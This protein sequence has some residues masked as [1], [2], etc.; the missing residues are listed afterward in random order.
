M[1]D[2]VSAFYT[3]HPGYLEAYDRDHGPRL[4]S[5]VAHWDLKRRLAGQRVLDVGGGLGFLGKRLEGLADYHAIDGAEVLPNQRVCEGTF[6]CF[7]LDH[8]M[9]GSYRDTIL[10][11]AFDAAFCLETLEHIGNP[12][13][14]LVQ[15]K[16]L[17]K[18]GGHV[19]ISLPTEEVWHNVPYPG[20]MWPRQNWEQFLGQMALPIAAFWHYPKPAWGWPAYHWWCENRPWSEKRLL[21][22]KA[23]EKF[24]NCTPLEATNL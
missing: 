19:I 8:D 5:L 2:I 7:D 13:H 22:P 6:H 17:V 18:P 21:F 12:H 20:L 11:G 4:D 14:A 24:R 16:Q 15:I 10:G 9:F 3:K 1:D 23:E